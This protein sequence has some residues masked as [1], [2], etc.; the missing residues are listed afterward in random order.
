MRVCVG[1]RQEIWFVRKPRIRDSS[2]WMFD[3]A[4]EWAFTN[5]VR[6]SLWNLYEVCNM[7]ICTCVIAILF[8]GRNVFVLSIIHTSDAYY[9]SKI[10]TTALLCTFVLL[11]NPYAKAGIETRFF[12]TCGCHALC[13]I[14]MYVYARVL[15]IISQNCNSRISVLKYFLVF[16]V[17]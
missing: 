15:L 2:I 3:A 14:R 4:S 9:I 10:Y 8:L 6:M 5:H 1:G 17:V 12:C 11:K 13:C 16:Y 7:Y